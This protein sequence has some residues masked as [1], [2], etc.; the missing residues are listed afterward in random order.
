M[1]LVVDA[2]VRNSY[3]H[4]EAQIVSLATNAVIV[5]LDVM[6]FVHF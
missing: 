2:C 3:F 4:L 6:R 1:L 5:Y